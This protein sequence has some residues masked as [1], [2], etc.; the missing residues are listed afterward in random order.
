M[1]PLRLS[2]PALVD[3]PNGPGST[4][5]CLQLAALLVSDTH[6]RYVVMVSDPAEHHQGLDVEIAGLSGIVAFGTDRSLRYERA[7]RTPG[8]AVLEELFAPSAT[9]REG[10]PPGAAQRFIRQHLTIAT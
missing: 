9:Y 1:P 3:L 6:G 5:A 2:A 7:W 10:S 4:L 8:M